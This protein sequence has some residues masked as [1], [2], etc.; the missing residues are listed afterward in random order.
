LQHGLHPVDAVVSGIPFST[1]DEAAGRNVLQQV[2]SSL[3]PGGVFVSYQIRGDVARLARDLMGRP[4]TGIELR[5][6]P[7]IRIYS[8]RKPAV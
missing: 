7:P 6:V 2:W 5:N 4:H 1:M 3:R 8:W